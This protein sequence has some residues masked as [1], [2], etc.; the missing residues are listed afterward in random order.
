MDCDFETS[1]SSAISAWF[2][3]YLFPNRGKVITSEKL[4]FKRAHRL[5]FRK[6][7]EWRVNGRCLSGWREEKAREERQ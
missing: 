5:I 1:D 4:R 3:P 6:V 2:L 7:I